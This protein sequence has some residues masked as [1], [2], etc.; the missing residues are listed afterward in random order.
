MKLFLDGLDAGG[1]G[2]IAMAAVLVVA[3]LA[4]VFTR[5]RREAAMG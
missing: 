5:R 3:W 1:I 2:V 4:T